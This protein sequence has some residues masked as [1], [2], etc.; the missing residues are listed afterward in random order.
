M[1]GTHDSLCAYYAGAMLLCALKPEA[2]DDFEAA[3]VA[4]DPLFAHLPRRRGERLEAAVAEWIASGVRLPR[5]HRE[6]GDHTVVVVGYD[7][8]PSGRLWLRLL[9]PVRATEVME[10]D[11]IRR[12]AHHIEL[13]QP[14]QHAGPRPDKLTTLRTATGRTTRLDRWDPGTRSWVSIHRNDSAPGRN[15]KNTRPRRRQKLENG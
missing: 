7:R 11:Q 13:I 2:E 3:E 5:L 10:L 6:M 4:E 14:I 15:R 9:D 8:Y 12:L 1:Q